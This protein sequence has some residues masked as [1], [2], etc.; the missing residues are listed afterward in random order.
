[1]QQVA[2][3]SSQNITN[4]NLTPE[5]H[6]L[7]YVSPHKDTGTDNLYVATSVYRPRRNIRISSFHS[8]HMPYS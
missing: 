5:L 8:L 1:M 2:K 3:Y 4:L 7:M 6:L